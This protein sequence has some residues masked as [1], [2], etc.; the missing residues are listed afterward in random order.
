MARAKSYW[1]CQECGF[2]SSGFLGRCT[3]CGSWSSL[4]EEFAKEEVVSSSKLSPG[5]QA[6]NKNGSNGHVPVGPVLLQDI[7]TTTSDRIVTGILGLDEVLG[8]GLVPGAVILLAGDPGI[9]KSTLLLQL[10][11]SV[12]AFKKVLYVSGEE[13]AAQIRLRASRLG[14]ESPQLYVTAEQNIGQISEQMA[15]EPATVVIVD[16]IQAVFHPEL[17]SAP[18]SVSQVR[19]SAQVLINMA[20]A[21]NITT[22]IVGHVNKEGT[23]AGPRVLEHM[24]DVVLQFQGDLTRQIRVLRAAKNRFGST[25]E[26]AIFSMAENGLTEVE[27]ASAFF[28]CDRL[29]NLGKQAP[30]G[31]AVI[32]GGEGHRIL[33]LEVQALVSISAY[34][35]PRRVANG[36]DYS[37]LLQILAVLEKKMGLP[38]ARS[39]VYVNI[40]GGL[41]FND[42]SGDLGIC[43]AI[44][45][46]VLDRSIDPGLLIIGE[47]GLT[48][49]V[50]PVAL[51]NEKLKEATRLGFKRAIVPKSGLMKGASFE[52]L[53]VIGVDSLAEAL[54]LAMPGV[55]FGE[56]GA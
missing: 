10:A 45:T 55:K 7:D 23:I 28:L 41:D 14:V 48:G 26:I 6:L 51:L 4:V 34:P 13:S 18:G 11:K 39:D 38:L 43:V 40:V 42:P 17:A 20:K 15:L 37:R 46:S 2:Q 21:H 3:D 33:L 19:E 22:I 25:S 5:R 16:S 44:A 32:A 52:P 24:V 1:V 30:S 56:R 47:V 29:S 49:E 54:A 9:G 31:T 50:R 36:W 35:N 27:N 8:G 12:A 53:K